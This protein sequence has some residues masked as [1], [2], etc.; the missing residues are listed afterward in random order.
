MASRAGTW[1]SQ[2]A[3]QS[4]CDSE[5]GSRSAWSPTT[6]TASGLSLKHKVRPRG[7]LR[8]SPGETVADAD[9]RRFRLLVGHDGDRH[10]HLSELQITLGVFLMRNDRVA[11][12][13]DRDR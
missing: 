1:I 11:V 12:I 10:H 5:G 8:G 4:L 13:T 3:P 2:P 9:G 7:C 6:K